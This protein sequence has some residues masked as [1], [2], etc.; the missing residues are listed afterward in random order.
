MLCLD[1]GNSR[2]KWGLSRDLGWIW[3]AQGA[4]LYDDA[5][6][7]ETLRRTLADSRPRQ[8]VACN[9]AGDQG[10]RAIAA[11]VA[12]LPCPLDWLVSSSAACGVTNR[13]EQPR[14]LGNDRWAA[15]IGA[16]ALHSGNAIVVMTGTA[17]TI[18]ALDA[19][20]NFLGGL[21][22][23]G[24]HLMHAILAD[25]TANLPLAQGCYRELPRN[26]GDAIASGAL[27]ATLGAIERIARQFDSPALVLLSGGAA[28]ALAEAGGQPYRLVDNL[29]LEGLR[30]YGRRHSALE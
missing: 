6:A 17:T 24:L 10:A 13:Y 12:E 4:L 20:G 3:I 27:H 15:S 8:V 5:N 11:I 29:V 2:L 21:I 28:V 25:K 7:I 19:H 23:P 22:L 26:T 1:A 30:R 14:Q 9:V 18:D 16:R